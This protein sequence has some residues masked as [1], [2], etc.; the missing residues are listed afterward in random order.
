M[1]CTLGNAATQYEQYVYK[2]SSNAPPPIDC[3]DV[4]A[5][6]VKGGVVL[7]ATGSDIGVDEV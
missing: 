4:P 5:S 2:I 1:R 7:I 6:A 3:E